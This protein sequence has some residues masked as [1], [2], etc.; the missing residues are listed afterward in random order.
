MRVQAE[1]VTGPTYEPISLSEAKAQLSIAASDTSHDSTLNQMITEARQQW[2]HDTDSITCFQTWKVRLGYLED[3]FALPKQPVESITSI[4]YFDGN[5]VSQ[6][7]TA[8]LYQLHV[9][10]F[11]LA[12]QVTLPAVVDRWDAWTINYRVGYSA[13][14]LKVPA[15]AKRAMLLLIGN[16]F[17]N[18]DML[19]SE[20]YQS[21]KSYESLV[22]KFMR[23]TYP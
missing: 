8:S 6:T 13:D 12:Y 18:R 11:R 2:E 4:T 17:E 14:G 21:Q 10:E 3:R 7:L 5:N 15:I 20:A 9:N 22:T 16:Y 23:S 19:M 1:L